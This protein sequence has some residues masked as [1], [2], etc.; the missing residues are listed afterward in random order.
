MISK[1][2]TQASQVAQL[3]SAFESKLS[4]IALQSFIILIFMYSSTVYFDSSVCSI[5]VVDHNFVYTVSDG[6]HLSGQIHLSE[7][8]YDEMAHKDVWIIEVL[9]VFYIMK[10]IALTKI[11]IKI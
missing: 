6:L 5:R 7:H 11:C 10:L 2:R 3:F 1:F 8:F 4:G 9:L